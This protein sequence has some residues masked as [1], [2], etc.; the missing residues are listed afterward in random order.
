MN[1]DSIAENWRKVLGYPDYL[2]ELSQLNGIVFE[3]LKYPKAP[4]KIK[5]LPPQAP[6]VSIS[7]YI[8][9]HY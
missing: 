6:V 1:M 9:G 8:L 4:L 2:P 3:C 5:E 7:L